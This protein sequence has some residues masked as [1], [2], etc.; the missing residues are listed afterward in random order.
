MAQNKPLLTLAQE[1]EIVQAYVDKTSTYKELAEMFGVHE[2]T[3]FSYLKKHGVQPHSRQ[4][5]PKD[6]NKNGPVVIRKIE[7]R[8]FVDLPP[9]EIE[10]EAPVVRA[11]PVMVQVDKNQNV[12]AVQQRRP[13]ERYEV[14]YSGVIVIEA[15]SIE[16][17]LAEARKVPAIKK[18]TSVGLRNA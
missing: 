14:K 7:P 13:L 8:A 4:S 5:K 10:V 15:D 18:I 11:A 2:T 6:E 9:A 3:I 12:Q 1:K 17:A 16:E